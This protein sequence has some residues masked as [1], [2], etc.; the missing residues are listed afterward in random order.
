VSGF[1][2]EWSPQLT[3]KYIVD[4][5]LRLLLSYRLTRHTS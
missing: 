3:S 5:I 2:D 1:L 4:K